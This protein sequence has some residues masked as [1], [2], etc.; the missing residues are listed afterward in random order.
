[1]TI[2]PY[3]PIYRR[4]G[5]R[6]VRGQGVHLIDDQGR[7]YLDFAAGI[8]VN[9]FGHGHPH[10][11]AALQT[12]ATQLWHCSN[13][14]ITPQLERFAQ[15]LVEATFADS[16]FF[17][18][19]GTE[20][21][22]A[23]IK[24]MRRYHYETGAPYRHRIVTFEGGFHGRTY[25]G[26]SA[27]GNAQARLGFGQML[28]GFDRVPFNDIEAVMARVTKNSA[29]ILIE[30]IQG[31]GGVQIA[32]I[33]FLRQLREICDANGL[34]L[35]CDEVQ[36]GYGRPGSFFAFERA[37]IT[38][39]IVSVA[40]GIGGGFPL[41]ATLVSARVGEVLPAGSHGGTYN[42]NPLAMAVGNAVL[43]LLLAEG[44][45]AQV[46]ATGEALLS[47]LKKLQ[48]AHPDKIRDVRGVG[49]MIGLEPVGDARAF[50]ARLLA[51]GLVTS[52]TVSNVI[53][54]MPPLTIEENHVREALQMIETLLQT[55]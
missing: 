53:R 2:T 13:Q 32:D 24:F 37:G 46:R 28:S 3:L 27:G 20:A 11:V 6:M 5:V 36:C 10:L 35:M 23:G 42:N 45:F 29:G 25:G 22:E 18:S 8:A 14:F 39:D 4:S 34:L 50:A 19:S 33:A 16:V 52:V 47:G 21:V 17:C 30:P 40:K 12:Q 54:L 15:R 9:A 26:I 49:L 48:A 41:G 38:P 7:R 1:M 44:L 55:E 51:Q 43:D 31:E